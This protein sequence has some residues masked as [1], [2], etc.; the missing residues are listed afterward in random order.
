MIQCLS[1]CASD[2]A[3]EAFVQGAVTRE[4]GQQKFHLVGEHPLSLQVNILGMCR[5][6]R[7]GEQRHVRLFRLLSGLVVVAALAGRNHIFP[8]IH[9][10][11]RERGDMVAR[12]LARLETPATIQAQVRVTGKKGGITE[13]R[14]VMIA[15]LDQA[16][17]L[18]LRGDNGIHLDDASMPGD[19]VVPTVHMVQ[20]Y[21]AGIGNLAK[22]VETDSVFIT[23]PLQWLARDIRSEYLLTEWIHN[24]LP[25]GNG[26]KPVGEWP[27]GRQT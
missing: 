6:K 24:I 21:P 26:C 11:T 23:D 4:V 19:R 3:C 14:S 10:A 17:V 13:W 15:R 2:Q 25:V 18:A 8:A 27:A 5:H 12:Q 9:A 16:M 7:N 20:R 22:V 1:E